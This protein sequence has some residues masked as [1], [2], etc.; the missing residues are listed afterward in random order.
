MHA[1]VN[2]GT[3]TRRFLLEQTLL[4]VMTEISV[5]LFTTVSL[6]EVVRGFHVLG[7][8]KY[9]CTTTTPDTGRSMLW[10]PVLIQRLNC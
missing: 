5:L 7:L 1:V 8:P 6:M 10:V 4:I 2:L 3:M 9:I